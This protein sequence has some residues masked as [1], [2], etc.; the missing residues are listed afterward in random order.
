M[1]AGGALALLLTGANPATGAEVMETLELSERPGPK[2]SWSI[3]PAEVKVEPDD[4]VTFVLKNTG[5]I[6]HNFTVERYPEA[7]VQEVWGPGEERTVTFTASREGRFAY[8][9]DVPGHREQGMEGVL[10]VGAAPAAPPPAKPT[11]GMEMTWLLLAAGGA[12]LVL[13]RGR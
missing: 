13:R 1:I 9:C 8:W 6:P 2:G 4:E 5:N 3:L 7:S 11:P 12:A 10:V